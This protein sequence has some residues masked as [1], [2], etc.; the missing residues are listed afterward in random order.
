MG[1][2]P[3]ELDQQSEAPVKSLA[4]V[5]DILF[6]PRGREAER[7]LT[8]LEDRF[9]REVA[10]LRQELADVQDRVNA[11]TRQLREEH[12]HDRREASTALEGLRQAMASATTNAEGHQKRYAEVRAELTI[13]RDQL[14]ATQQQVLALGRTDERLRE[15]AE[16]FAAERLDRRALAALFTELADRICPPEGE[17]DS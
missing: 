16:K 7:R 10:A 4:K 1:D 3:S 15:Q 8:A 12:A 14:Q 2:S 6:G 17:P 5:R 13:V 9:D 11:V